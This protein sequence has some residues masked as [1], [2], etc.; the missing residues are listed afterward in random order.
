MIRTRYANDAITRIHDM[1]QPEMQAQN[2][3]GA[4]VEKGGW[5][6]LYGID[7]NKIGEEAR[8]AEG[9][10]KYGT[11]R[12]LLSGVEIDMQPERTLLRCILP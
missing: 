6:G 5:V 2:S 10:P 3:V 11:E 8:R 7:S 1:R 9:L 12:I 4:R